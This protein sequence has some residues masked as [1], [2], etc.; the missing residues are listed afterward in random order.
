MTNNPS[1]HGALQLV[2]C[3]ALFSTG[4]A[5]IKACS[6]GGWQ[7]ASL[8]SLVAAT[9]LALFIPEARR[10]RDARV[11]LIAVAYAATLILFVR[12]TK[13]TTAASAIFLQSV[14]PLY[15]LLL[16]PWLLGERVRARDLGFLAAFAVGLVFLLSGTATPLVSAPDPSLGNKLATA[17]GVTWAFTI[18]GL[19]HAARQGRGVASSALVVGNLFAWLAAFP[20]ALPI[21]RVGAA[22]V[23]VLVYLGVVQIGLA[24]LLMTRGMRHVPALEA[25]LVLLVE[26]V[27]N[28][29]WAW[30]LQKEV[31][32][33]A[34]LLGGAV[35]VCTTALMAWR[36]GNETSQEGNARGHDGGG[37][38]GEARRSDPAG[39]SPV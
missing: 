10:V 31:P 38:A 9:A 33:A 23:A 34:S 12:A 22:D 21:P 25:S 32:E 6:L 29:L 1:R 26:P 2:A 8:R 18:V 14:A 17:S 15:V 30:I 5:A 3:A 24:Y 7:V 19:R 28:P 16:G 13:L 4:G 37:G 20:F 11:V 39:G 35:I 36:G 27:L